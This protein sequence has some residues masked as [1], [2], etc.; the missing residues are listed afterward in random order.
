MK[1]FIAIVAFIA[2]GTI[3][4]TAQVRGV[5]G[6]IQQTTALPVSY[7]NAAGTTVA[8][9]T[10]VSADTGYI[11]LGQISNNL[12]LNINA[13]ITQVTG[14]VAATAILQA[15]DNSAFTYPYTITGTTTQCASCV[16][17]SATITAAGNNKWIVP[18]SPLQYYR[19]RIIKTDTG[20]AAYTGS[21]YM[22]W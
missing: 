5:Y 1:K 8:L 7:K 22:K 3:A 20:K 2:L 18:E 21:A 13:L 4:A 10:L 17:A 14:T 16:G 9:D 12:N 11:W 15:S 6:T 19:V